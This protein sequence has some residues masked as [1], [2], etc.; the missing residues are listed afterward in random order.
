MTDRVGAEPQYEA[1]ADDF[2]KH[3]ETSFANAHYDR[4]ACLGLLGDV[5]GRT[6]LDVACGPGYYAEELTARGATVIGFDLSP[7]MVELSRRRVP[8]GDFRVHNV[9]EPLDWLP[10]GSVDL[11]LFALAIDYVDDRVAALCEL[12]RVLRPDGALVFSR[13]HPTSDWLRKGGG[14]YDVRV[15]DELWSNG[16][17]RV[18]YWVLPLERTCEELHE[19]GFLIERLHEPRPTEEAARLDPDDYER[20]QREPGFLAIRAIPDPRSA[21]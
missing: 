17:W 12:R 9:A 13:Q 21:A 2:D 11:V 15:V 4:P 19:A 20:L 6:V 3:A 1:F 7:R 10:S 8:G 16:A 18:R 14:Y 5:A